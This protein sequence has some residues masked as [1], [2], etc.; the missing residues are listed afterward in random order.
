MGNKFVDLRLP[1]GFTSDDIVKNIKKLL[2]ISKFTFNIEK[3]SLD[4]RN[5]K[6]ICWVVKILV[7]SEE[8]A[9][10]VDDKN[11]SIDIPKINTDKK[12]VIVGTG[13]AGIFSA[14]VLLEAGFKVQIIELGPEVF[15]RTKKV[16]NFEKTG[17]LN[18]RANY[19]FG[20]GGA[21]TFSDG[22]LTSRTKTINKE[23]KYIFNKYVE[24]GAPEEIKF[25]AKPHIGSNI[26]TKIVKNMRNDF[27]AKGG[28]IIFDNKLLNFKFNNGVVESI[29]TEKG[30]IEADYFI[31]AIGHSS[32]DT[33]QMLIKNQV[34][35]KTKGFAIGSRVE[36]HQELINKAMWKVAEIPG[37]KAADYA[38][39]YDDDKNFPCYSFCMCPGGMV[40]PAAYRKGVNLVNGMSNYK[41]NYPFANSAIIA[42]FGIDEILRRE[43]EPLEALDW[44]VNLEEK[45]YEF[46]NSYNAPAV[47]VID[48][49]N[50]KQSSTFGKSSYPFEL[51][52]A[53]FNTL[54]PKK[55]INSMKAGLQEFHKKIKGFET[56]ILIG[57]ESKT[58]SPIQVIR[59]GMK[60]AGFE[61]LYLAGEGT[62]LSGGIV[63]S[64]ADGIKVAFDI[65][66]KEN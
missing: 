65:I 18:E 41:R 32:I 23:K 40:V 7:N 43:V 21:G 15:E 48:F 5:Y 25:L 53:D 9:G 37:I 62:G 49:L 51:L 34:K 1:I 33:L 2:G 14:I 58:S 30:V 16:R 64:A 28:E 10:I 57:L 44:I 45:F 29:D 63:S 22:K 24:Y 56:G 50:N 12:V 47:N 3:Q 11:Q 17:E 46:S 36:H 8:I 20:E 60:C 52:T 39:T 55:V 19:A 26:L 35:F 66:L 4:S 38:V 6:N 27:I 13:P 54:L 59:D 42:A 61:N 31:F